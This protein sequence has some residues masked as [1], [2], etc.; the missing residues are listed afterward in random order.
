MAGGMLDIDITYKSTD[1]LGHLADDLN[2]STTVTKKIVEDID[3]TLERM[4][5]GDFTRGADNPDL[6]KQ[7]VKTGEVKPSVRI[8]Y[9]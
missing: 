1:E 5:G 4:A 9:K 6:Y 3:S 7:Y 8:T 2:E